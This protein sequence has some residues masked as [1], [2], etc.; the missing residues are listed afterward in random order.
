MRG[1]GHSLYGLGLS[2]A[3]GGVERQHLL[4]HL[5]CNSTQCRHVEADRL[6]E[7]LDIA[8]NAFEAHLALGSL[9]VSGTHAHGVQRDTGKLVNDKTRKARAVPTRQKHSHA[10][11]SQCQGSGGWCGSMQ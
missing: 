11:V 1:K 8:C 9:L 2:G 3:D 7:P 6:I 4:L 10:L 5:R